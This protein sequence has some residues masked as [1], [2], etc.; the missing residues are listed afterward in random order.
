MVPSQGFAMRPFALSLTWRGSLITCLSPPCSMTLSWSA[1]IFV[2]RIFPQPTIRTMTSHSMISSSSFITPWLFSTSPASCPSCSSSIL[3]TSRL[4]SSPQ[5]FLPSQVSVTSIFRP[6]PSSVNLVFTPFAPSHF[7][8]V[9]LSSAY[10][11]SSHSH[12]WSK[13]KIYNIMTALNISSLHLSVSLLFSFPSF[14]SSFNCISLKGLLS[15]HSRSASIIQS[16]CSHL[17]PFLFEA[18]HLS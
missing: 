5:C 14:S 12:L 2:P 1:F 11:T 16:K 6:E 9:F 17:H 4:P 15:T 3:Y 8:L 10:P 13:K 18:F 7:S